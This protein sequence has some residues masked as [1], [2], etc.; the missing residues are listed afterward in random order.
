MKKTGFEDEV[1][2]PDAKEWRKI[3]QKE[4][5]RSWLKCDWGTGLA[6][7]DSCPGD[8]RE[9]EC[10]EFTTEFSDYKGECGGT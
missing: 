4:W 7:R 10:V 1:W 3:P 2:D 6:G 8:P 5:R 9:R